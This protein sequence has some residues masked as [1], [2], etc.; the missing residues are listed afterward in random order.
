[1]CWL[2]LSSAATASVSQPALLPLLLLPLCCQVLW[3]HY[4]ERFRNLQYLEAQL[5]SYQKYAI[6]LHHVT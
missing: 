1:M 5:D 2:Q 6:I 4:L 3:L